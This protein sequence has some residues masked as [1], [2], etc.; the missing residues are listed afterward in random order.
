MLTIRDAATRLGISPSRVRQF[1]ADGRLPIHR[2]GQRTLL[3]DET[4]LEP[5]RAPRAAGWKPGRPRK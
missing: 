2:Y 3:I 4:A 5:L 1:I